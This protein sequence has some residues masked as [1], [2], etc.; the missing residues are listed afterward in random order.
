MTESQT[1]T[2]TFVPRNPG[3][4]TIGPIKADIEGQTYQTEPIQ[5]EVTRES[6]PKD[7]TASKNS[8]L[9]VT[10]QVNN[11]HPY[12]NERVIYTFRFF[13]KVSTGNYQIKYPDFKGFWVEQADKREFQQIINGERY[14]INEE[15]KAIYPTEAGNL[16]IKPAYFLVEY[17]YKE[18]DGFGGIFSQTRSEIKKFSTNPIRISAKP[19]PANKPA[20]FSGLVSSQVNLSANLSQTTA[21]VGDSLT[22]SL[23]L[24]GNGNINDVKVPEI[25]LKDNFKVYKDKPVERSYNQGDN[26]VSEKTFKYALVP[27]KAGSININPLKISYFNTRTKRFEYESSQPY[28]LNISPSDEGD[29]ETISGPGKNDVKIIGEDIFSIHSDLDSLEQH[30]LTA[31]KKILYL[32]WFLTPLIIYL[33]TYL[34]ASEKFRSIKNYKTNSKKYFKN[35][36]SKIKELEVDIDKNG[37]ELPEKLSG[38]FKDYLIH[39]LNISPNAIGPENIN[40]QI[41]SEKMPHEL[42]KEINDLFEKYEYLK[43]SGNSISIDKKKELLSSTRELLNRLESNK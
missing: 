28:K 31:Y 1:L 40:K 25:D 41:A 23:T 27:L 36:L 17:L 22:L 39:K 16:L 2:Y 42:A 32:L 6:E 24:K 20:D 34:F 11:T 29:L 26:I 4:Y 15:K 3:K 13:R 18:D 43:F 8:E 30:G 19:L 12:Q 21:K 10:A 37:N 14:L 35:S 9:F 38:L 33:L 5:I 7:S